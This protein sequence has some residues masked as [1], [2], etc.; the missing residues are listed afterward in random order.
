MNT[1]HYST[2]WRVQFELDPKGLLGGGYCHID[3][4]A[5]VYEDIPS[6]DLVPG[7]VIE[8]PRGGC[9]MQCDA[10]LVS[11]NCIV[12]ES[13][14]TGTFKVNIMYNVLYSKKHRYYSSCKTW[15]RQVAL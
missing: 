4:Y 3:F 11:G 6:D 2:F 7:D 15:W 14:L 10:V 13:M 5:L 1:T 8:I 12:N 9:M